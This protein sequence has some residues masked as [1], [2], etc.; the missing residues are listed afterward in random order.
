FAALFLQGWRWDVLPSYLWFLLKV[1]GFAIAATWIR[2]T[3][4]RLRPD[5]ILAFAW[6][7][8]FPVSMVNVAALSVQRLWLGGADGTLTSSDL[9]LMAAIN[10]PLAIVSVAVMGRVARLREQAPRVAAMEAR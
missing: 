2:A 6:K 10:W 3:L 1:G 8:L 5:Q 7:F 9:W 4:P